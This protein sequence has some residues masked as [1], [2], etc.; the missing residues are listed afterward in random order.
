MH[1]VSL[2]ETGRLWRLALPLMGRIF[3]GNPDA[4]T[5]LSDSTIN[6]ETPKNLADAFKTAGFAQVDWKT[7]MFQTVAV[8]WAVR[9]ATG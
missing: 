5:Y 4:Y 6:F 9:P 2:A 7:F 1:H 8:H 3:A